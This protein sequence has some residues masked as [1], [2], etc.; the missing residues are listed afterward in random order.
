MP[1]G[2]QKPQLHVPTQKV[3]L[4]QEEVHVLPSDLRADQH[5]PEEVDLPPVGLV[6]QHEAPLLHH[7]L[8]NGRGH[9]HGRGG[10]R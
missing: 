6:A 9:L 1:L 4:I 5:L 2:D 3:Y 10:R 7:P 8:L